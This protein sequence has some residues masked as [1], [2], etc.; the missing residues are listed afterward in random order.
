MTTI[1][2]DV[3]KATVWADTQSTTSTWKG[4]DE[5][6]ATLSADLVHKIFKYERGILTGAGNKDFIYECAS[7]FRD[8]GVLPRPKA[9]TRII[10]L[11]GS[12]TCCK[13]ML[14]TPVENDSV[15]QRLMGRKYKWSKTIIE[16]HQVIGSG[17]YY[18]L[19]ALATGVSE[20]EAIKAASKVDF[21]TN[22]QIDK[23]SLE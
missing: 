14:Y 21:Y 10:I 8:E 1:I 5:S 9:G 16:K 3:D 4:S 19:G 20:E 22:D 7:T 12:K 18:A 17:E 11:F 23:E 6:G 13:G 2:A 15:W